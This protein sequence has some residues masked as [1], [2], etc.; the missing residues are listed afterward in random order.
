M[1]LSQ[2]V[3]DGEC[4]TTFMFLTAWV[5]EAHHCPTLLNENTKTKL[6][7]GKSSQ[8]GL[9]HFV[10]GCGLVEHQS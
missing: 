5:F 4:A 9:K 3:L 1:F 7:T 2:R 10:M 6:Q 8:A